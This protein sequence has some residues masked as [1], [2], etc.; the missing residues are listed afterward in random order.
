M[1]KVTYSQLESALRNAFVDKEANALS[2][3]APDFLFN[4]KDSHRKVISTLVEELRKADSFD[5]S[6]AFINRAGIQLFMETFA[7]LSQRGVKG[8]ILTT[9][10]LNFTE[11]DALD[12]L[13]TNFPNIEVRMYKTNDK[14]NDGF[15]TKGY[16]IKQGD[17]YKI[18]IGS[19]N[20]TG[21]ALT[22]N[23][24]WNT[25]LVSTQEG[26][27]IAKVRAEFENL[28][29]Q[30]TKLDDY[31]DTY[32]KIYADQKK[33]EE[34]EKT[35]KEELP[36]L[37]PNYMQTS[38]TQRIRES[39]K[40]GDKR[41]LLISATG[42][43]KTFASA[44][45]LRD[46]GAKHILFLAHRTQLLSQAI[47]SYKRVMP[48]NSTFA[49]FTGDESIAEKIDGVNT[50]DPKS[51]EQYNLVFSTCEMMGKE[52][53]RSEIDP[54]QFDYI[55]IDEVHHAGSPTYQNILAYF[56][57]SFFLGMT[58]TPE[59]TEDPKQVFD[60][61]DNNIIFE[62]RLEDALDQDLLCPF[63]Y[64]GITDMKGINDE[65]YEKKD[66]AKLFSDQRIDY[67]LK[68]AKFYGHSG[69]RLR[70]LIFCSRKEDGRILETRLNER[71]LKTKFICGEDDEKTREDT[72][73]LL[74]ETNTSKPYLDYIITIDIFNE[75][76]DIPEVNQ[77]LLL[78][79]TQSSII[80]I[81]QLGRGLRKWQLK[82][83]VVIIDFIG[84]YDGNYMIPLAFS[85]GGGRESARVLV[86]TGYIPGISTVEFD[87]IAREK[88]LASL[89]N[90]NLDSYSEIKKQYVYLKDKLN[91][92]PSYQDF[93]D[94]TD[95]DPVR[96]FLGCDS[97][98]SLKVRCGDV[99][100]FSEYEEKAL[101]ALSK[102]LGYGIRVEEALLLK[103][104]IQH[105]TR[106][107]FEKTLEA[108]PYSKS[109]K[110]GLYKTMLSILSGAS[111]SGSH[112]PSF[113]TDDFAIDPVFEKAL[114]ANPLFASEVNSL[115]DFSLT[116]N[117]L[118]YPTHYRGTDF[119][120]FQRYT[121]NDVCQILNFGKLM[122]ST[123]YGYRYNEPTNTYPIF[124]NYV[125]DPKIS[126]ETKYED[127]LLNPNV[128][129]WNSRHDIKMD[130]KEIAVLTNYKTSKVKVYLFIRK[131]NSGVGEDTAYH[132]FLGEVVPRTVEPYE[133]NG[134]LYA[135]VIF[136]LMDT[137]R[138]DIYNYLTADPLSAASDEKYKETIENENR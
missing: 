110:P 89:Q 74:E 21:S 86:N 45:A 124:I 55:V 44:F 2:T 7:E 132:Y 77:V 1:E 91:R 24:E 66:F 107:D 138:T 121:R 33:R 122:G 37:T 20:I 112:F 82:D 114:Q 35:V 80:F 42:T 85:N 83:F 6:V 47:D 52:E 27:Y 56:H 15:H 109:V 10:Y 73:D 93:L 90:V 76:V 69:D 67:I 119:T 130:M 51:K 100:P 128:F 46:L 106:E 60:L 103:A 41:G 43:G 59:R 34:A 4:D 113:I 101:V 23:K 84:N 8:R 126:E 105:Q 57:P 28:W 71:G 125:K 136:D 29:N 96:I 30:G 102:E 65:T 61:F 137:V 36:T 95:F 14:E 81:Q 63:H 11:P 111:Y 53:Y 39:V 40:R 75:G 68:E 108:K 58:A 3:Y 116:R 78:R 104:L 64:Y 127:Q 115:L 88:V 131:Q 17:I 19:S 32:R 118:K 79:P 97:Y 18:I 62:I 117:Q 72:I 123:L 54:N 48:V 50:Y 92:I 99:K 26:D 31:L 135:H 22:V 120:L 12:I 16:I 38:F 13:K 134:H 5:I 87:Q 98:H 129:S 9:D 49:L 25:E 70:G 94:F 133:K